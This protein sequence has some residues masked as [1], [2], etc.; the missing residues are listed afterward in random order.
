ME[1]CP[2]RNTVARGARAGVVEAIVAESPDFRTQRVALRYRDTYSFTAPS[3]P[4]IVQQITPIKAVHIQTLR[5]AVTA[6]EN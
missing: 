6:L 5:D 2:E 3:N 4:T 1:R